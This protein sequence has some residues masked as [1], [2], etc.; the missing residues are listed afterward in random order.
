MSYRYY[1]TQRPVMPGSYPKPGN[2]KVEEICNFDNKTYSEEIQTNAWGYIEYEKPLGHFDIVGY[3]L[4]A[5]KTKT[6]HLKY[7]GRDS[8]GRYVYEDENG[9][10]WKNTD[11]CSPRECCTF[12]NPLTSGG[13]SVVDDVELPCGADCENECSNCVIQKIMNEYATLE[14]KLLAAEVL[15]ANMADVIRKTR[16]DIYNREFAE[17]LMKETG[18]TAE[19]LAECGI[20]EKEAITDD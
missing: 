3:E 18:I 1:S 15:I 10:L 12:T 8:W 4:V 11:C 6:L 20:M 5:V 2:N 13:K 16:Q 14:N 17:F 19:E 9:K 7:R